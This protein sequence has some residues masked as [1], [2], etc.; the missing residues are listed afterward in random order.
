M[1][2]DHMKVAVQ[3]ATAEISRQQSSLTA[4]DKDLKEK[5]EYISIL[6]KRM[7]RN[8]ITSETIVNDLKA[9][10]LEQD[11]TIH[12]LEEKCLTQ[13]NESS[14]EIETFRAEKFEISIKLQVL[15]EIN[16]LLSWYCGE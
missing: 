6:E 13:A 5:I 7:E 11:E 9:S 3:E 8:K 10:I 15:L 2:E 16:F 4:K 14:S 1:M 12:S